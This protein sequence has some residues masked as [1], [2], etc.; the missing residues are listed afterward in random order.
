[1]AEPLPRH[2]RQDKTTRGERGR[3]ACEWG[4]GTTP[5]LGQ[6]RDAPPGLWA[7]ACH[8]HELEHDVG[9]ERACKYQRAHHGG[10]HKEK[11]AKEYWSPGQTPQPKA[12]TG[13]SVCSTHL[14]DTVP[15][16]TISISRIMPSERNVD[17]K[18]AVCTTCHG[19]TRVR[20]PPAK[21][22]ISTHFVVCRKR[23]S[24]APVVRMCVWCHFHFA[25]PPPKDTQQVQ[26]TT[27]G[28]ASP[29]TKR[30]C[31]TRHAPSPCFLVVSLVAS[32][33]APSSPAASNR[34]SMGMW[35]NA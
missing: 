18:P 31:G 9:G 25:P 15:S 2:T 17:P 14:M 21:S 20:A 27:S 30:P 10:C 33:V 19:R 4:L 23:K 16:Y 6:A 11:A 28:S 12:D 5:N 32:S 8:V 29:A 26:F 22:S 13:T 34:L 24:R 1:L 3:G 7:C 35:S